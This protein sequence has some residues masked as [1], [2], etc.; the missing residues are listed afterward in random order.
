MNTIT[1]KNINIQDLAK[2]NNNLLTVK[3]LLNKC[4]YNLDNIYI[5]RFWYN[6]KDDKWIYLDNE[7]ILW[8]EY[9]EIKIGKEKIIKFLKNHFIEN[10]DYKILNNLEFNINNFCAGVSGEQNN[11]EEKR[12]AHNKQYITVSSDC[13]KELCMHVGTNKSKEIKKYYIELEKVFKFYLEYQNEFQKFQLENKEQELLNAKDKIMD[14]ERDF[15]HTELEF[16]EFIYIATNENYHKQNVYKIGRSARLNKRTKQFNTFFINGHKIFYI[17][18]FQC[19]KSRILEQL[20]FTCLEKYKYCKINELFHL[21]LNKL[22]SI[23]FNIGC[24]YNK[25]INYT[26]LNSNLSYKNIIDT[27]KIKNKIINLLFKVQNKLLRDGD[28]VDNLIST[29][30][31]NYKNI[32]SKLFKDGDILNNLNNNIKIIINIIDKIIKDNNLLSDYE[33]IVKKSS[34]YVYNDFRLKKYLIKIY[35]KDNDKFYNIIT[36]FNSTDY[37]LI[38]I[39]KEFN[40]IKIPHPIVILRFLLLNLISLQLFNKNYNNTIFFSIINYF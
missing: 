6:I 2:N 16:D 21:E 25:I 13:F 1:L 38:P 3:E 15:E 40:T 28:R 26:L 27:N 29:I 10:E 14:M 11:D 7:L 12:G 9:K 39:V 37:E 35:D 31:T 20:L 8:L 5:D 24:Q 17:Y 19:H 32:D 36:L 22:L 23:V 34:F 18:V 33:I 4:N 30:N